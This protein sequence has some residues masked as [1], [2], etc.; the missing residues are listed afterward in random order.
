MTIKPFLI[1]QLRP[2]TP[3]ADNEFEAFL[4]KGGLDERDT[5]RVRLERDPLPDDLD[6]HSLSGVIVGGGPGCVSDAPDAKSP[7]EKKI[8]QAVFSLMPEITRH[9]IPFL[10]CCYG[11]GVLAH[12]LGAPVTKERYGEPVGPTQCR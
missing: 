2:E 10:G 9:D 7:E 12:H 6:L 5:I 4:D 8:E 3:A 11:I 1:L